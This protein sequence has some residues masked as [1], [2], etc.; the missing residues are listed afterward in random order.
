MSYQ[1]D[2][3]DVWKIGIWFWPSAAP[4]GDMEHVRALIRS[5]T[6]ET[7]LAILWIKDEFHGQPGYR[8]FAIYDAVLNH[9]VR[10][11]SQF[12]SYLQNGR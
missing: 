9:G 7:R 4:S 10:T 1:T 3:A 6:P 5:L 11:P 12:A 2:A 8:S